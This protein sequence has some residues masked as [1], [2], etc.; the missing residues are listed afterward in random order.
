M[1]SRPWSPGLDPRCPKRTEKALG[2]PKKPKKPK[3]PSPKHSKTIEKTKKNQK[4]LRSQQLG[5]ITPCAWAS[6][7]LQASIVAEILGFFGF[8][9]FSRWFCYGLGRHPLVFLIFLVFPMDLT[10]LFGGPS[11][12]GTLQIITCITPEH[13]GAGYVSYT[14]HQNM[15]C[16]PKEKH[17]L[18]Y[19]VG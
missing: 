11:L 17:F 4:N 8:F 5:S 19:I 7:G 15:F 16:T 12:V 10:P 2:K 9:W 6:V 18:Y 1:L 13:M 14:L 3:A